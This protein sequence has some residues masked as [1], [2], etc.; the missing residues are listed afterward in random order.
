MTTPGRPRTRAERH[1]LELAQPTANLAEQDARRL[2]RESE[3]DDVRDT[4]QT[5][6]AALGHGRLAVEQT[7]AGT[8]WFAWCECSWVSSTTNFESDAA[9]AAVHHVRVQLREWRRI[10]LPL[11][12]TRPAAPDWPR[13]L[14]KH[15][16]FALRY[17]NVDEVQA[18]LDGPRHAAPGADT[19]SRAATA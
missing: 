9:G 11:S 10:G 1:A 5:I 17:P 6:A 13:A 18:A 7:V 4:L 19:P 14:R 16:H 12:A 2:R 15:R 8:R 3:S